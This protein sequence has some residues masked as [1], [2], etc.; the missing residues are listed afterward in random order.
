ME[1]STALITGASRGIGAAIAEAL[2]EEGVSLIGVH[3]GHDRSAALRTAER[4]EKL[5][6]TAVLIEVDL[7]SGV[8][9]GVRIA[10]AWRAAVA[11]YGYSGTDIFVSNAGMNGAQSLSDLDGETYANVLDVNLTAPL[12]LLHSLVEHINEGGR[13]IGVSTGYVR[14]A[15]PT[16]VAYSASKAGFEGAFR[17]VAPELARRGITVNVVRP[18]VIDTDINADWIDLPGAREGAA[19]LS[20]F[21]GVGKPKDVAGV[22]RWLAGDAGGWVTGQAIDVTGGTGL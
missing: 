11:E 8:T 5:G 6:A 3:Y 1:R 18:G 16:H 21:N 19:G 17:S 4:I 7:S 15:A 13:V 2:A 9:A 20:A 14:I 12:F 22:V 10:E